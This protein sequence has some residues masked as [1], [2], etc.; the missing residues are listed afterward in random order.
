MCEVN[1]K[2]KK[3]LR[4]DNGVKVLYLRLMKALYGCMDSTLLW[5]DIYSKTLKSQGFLINA[6]GRCIEN[7]TIQDKQCTIV[8]YADDNKVSHID[9]EVNQK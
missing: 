5:Y 4:V 1:P 7:S 2:H 6:Y 8:W 3:N 9:E